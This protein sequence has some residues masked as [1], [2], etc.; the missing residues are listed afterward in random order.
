[1]GLL[2][3]MSTLEASFVEVLTVVK[4]EQAQRRNEMWDVAKRL[5]VVSHLNCPEVQQYVGGES[6]YSSAL[7][8]MLRSALVG[9]GVPDDYMSEVWDRDADAP[10]QIVRYKVVLSRFVAWRK[11]ELSRS[12]YKSWDAP[13][14]LFARMRDACISVLIGHSDL[15]AFTSKW[16][17]LDLGMG[18]EESDSD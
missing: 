10:A 18:S 5:D 2:N 12:G 13:L 6:N 14:A 16:I 7:S 15:E 8:G 3:D 11:F 4:A 9:L 17:L 1:M